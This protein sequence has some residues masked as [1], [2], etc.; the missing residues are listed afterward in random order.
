VFTSWHIFEKYYK[1]LDESPVY[2]AAL[3]LHLSQRKVYIQKNWPRFWHKKIFNSVKKL[4][5]DNYKGLPTIDSTPSLVPKAQP[6]E[7]NLLAQELDIIDTVSSVD[8]YKAYTSQ[9]AYPNWLFTTYLV[10]L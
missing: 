2:A 7:Y 3:I 5:E 1:L 8:E 9:D 10:A 4:W 6:D